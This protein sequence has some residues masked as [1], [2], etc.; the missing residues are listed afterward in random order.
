MKIAIVFLLLAV[1]VAAKA[2]G[3]VEGKGIKFGN[4]PITYFIEKKGIP[5]QSFESQTEPVDVWLQYSCFMYRKGMCLLSI[6]VSKKPTIKRDFPGASYDY[7]I[8]GV[9]SFDDG[10]FIPIS[11]SRSI[12]SY[13]ASIYETGNI[14]KKKLTKSLASNKYKTLSLN[15]QWFAEDIG[16]IFN[17]DVAGAGTE[18][19][20]LREMVGIP[21]VR[22]MP[23]PNKKFKRRSKESCEG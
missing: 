12:G 13:T 23:C 2:D 3:W 11:I 19:A 6:R 15:I 21:R 17:F 22:W 14:L 1:C 9:A 18:M 7:G 4:S 5:V 10:D 8:D 16:G 20:K